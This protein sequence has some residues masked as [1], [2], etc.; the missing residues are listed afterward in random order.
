MQDCRKLTIR[1]KI[2]QTMIMLPNRKLELELGGGSL[3]AYFER[4]PITGYFMGWKLFDGVPKEQHAEHVRK[5]VREYQAASELPLLFQEDYENGVG[6]PGMTTMPKLMSLGAA[7]SEELASAY[8][9]HNAREAWSVGVKWV[10]NPVADLNINPANPIV[11]TRCISDEPNLASRLLARV[12]SGIQ[13][14][15]VAATAKHFPGDGVDSRDQHLCTTCN[16]LSME[17]WRCQHGKVFQA[18]IDAGVMSIMPGHITLPAYQGPKGEYIDG[19]HPPATLSKALLTDLLKGE[20]GFNGVVVSDAMMMGGFRGYYASRIEGEIRSFLAGVDV[21]LWPSYEFMDEVERRINR[22]EIPMSRLDDAVSRVWEM[23]RKLGLLE[24]DRQLV[25]DMSPAEKAEAARDSRRICEAAVTLVRD[26]KQALPL[27]PGKDRK[28]LIVGVVPGSRKGGD[29]GFSR[30][31]HLKAELEKRGFSVDIRH[32]ILYETDYWES[33]L[34]ERYDRIIVAVMRVTHEPYGPLLFWDDEAQS[35][36]GINAMPKD[37]IIIVSLGSPYL[38]N[39]YFERVDICIN[40]YSR[41]EATLTALARTLTGEIAFK[42]LS[43]VRL[44]QSA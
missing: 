12:I 21:M 16:S 29:G 19:F 36:W 17:E 18:L 40:A 41:D 33:D 11:N 23:K 32:N 43:P 22:G 5:S 13:E 10:L 30:L 44:T 4:Y 39:T 26:R 24:P 42:G 37:K 25:R 20:M 28:I 31:E 15:H 3:K 1:Q 27:K 14:N 35:V 6:L 34:T 8:G 7:N 38:A 2:G 9:R